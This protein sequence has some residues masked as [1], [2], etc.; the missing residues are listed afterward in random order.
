MEKHDKRT[1][2]SDW[3]GTAHEDYR[4]FSEGS[5]ALDGDDDDK[6]IGCMITN[7]TVCTR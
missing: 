1:Q 4:R 3:Y 5:F 2:K 6:K 7:G